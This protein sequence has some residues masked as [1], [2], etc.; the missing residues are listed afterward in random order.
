MIARRRQGA[1]AQRG[2]FDGTQRSDQRAQSIEAPRLQTQLSDATTET[3][4]NADPSVLKTPRAPRRPVPRRVRRTTVTRH[5]IDEMAASPQQETIDGGAGSL[6]RQ[7]PSIRW[8]RET[9][10]GK[11]RAQISIARSSCLNKRPVAQ[12]WRPR[13]MA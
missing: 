1:L 3:V 8:M 2:R 12:L 5:R 7:R 10:V 4:V 6:D 9:R 13:R 11:P